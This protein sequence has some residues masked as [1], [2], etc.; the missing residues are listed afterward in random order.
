MGTCEADGLFK[1]GGISTD[2]GQA[3]VVT[4]VY[5]RGQLLSDEYFTRHPVIQE[6]GGRLRLIPAADRQE[7]LIYFSGLSQPAIQWN[8]GRCGGPLNVVFTPRI[9]NATQLCESCFD[10]AQQ[11]H[12]IGQK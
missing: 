8:C 12:Q 5:Y 3:C 6:H 9:Q 2:W 7:P 1:P 4:Y 11:P 10:E